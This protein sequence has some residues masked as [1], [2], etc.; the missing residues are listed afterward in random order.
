MVKF[1]DKNGKNYYFI[2]CVGHI[3]KY[4]GTDLL[5]QVLEY[6]KLKW[7]ENEDG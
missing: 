7:N 3:N 4:I 2:F 6:S 1:F 5:L